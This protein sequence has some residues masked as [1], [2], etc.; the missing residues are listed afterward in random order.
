MAVQSA[1][2][3]SATI[4]VSA[5]CTPCPISEAGTKKVIAPSP[6]M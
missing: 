3:S 6:S 1:S 4:M 2:I 5:V